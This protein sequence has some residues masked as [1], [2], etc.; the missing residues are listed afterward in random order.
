MTPI[1]LHFI[2]CD[3]V[4]YGPGN[5]HRINVYGLTTKIRSEQTPSF[6]LHQIL[7]TA[8]IIF[9]GGHGVDEFVVRIK[10][11]ATGR[12]VTRS[13]RPRR[14]QFVGDPD[15]ITGAVIR[16]RDCTFPTE[17]LYWIELVLGGQMIAR[18]PV[19]VISGE[20]HGE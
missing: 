12:I 4:S 15:E 16:I 9:Q 14:V 19:R 7:L 13:N 18:Q 1:V 8:L 2:P 20:N 3:D 17:G 10:H 5:L 11:K 6:P